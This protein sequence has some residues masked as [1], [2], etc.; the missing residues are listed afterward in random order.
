MVEI[1]ERLYMSWVNGNRSWV[2]SEL[3]RLPIEQ[4]FFCIAYIT[5]RLAG[6]GSRDDWTF[7]EFLRGRVQ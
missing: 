7:Q 2:M 4:A 1:A 3:V 6:N 5:R